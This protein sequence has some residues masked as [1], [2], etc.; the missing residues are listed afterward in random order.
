MLPTKIQ[1]NVLWVFFFCFLNLEKC[2]RGHVEKW[3]QWER[4]EKK[5]IIKLW[6]SMEIILYIYENAELKIYT[7]RH[8][9]HI[10]VGQTTDS[11][12]FS[13]LCIGVAAIQLKL[14]FIFWSWD[15]TFDEVYRNEIGFIYI[16]ISAVSNIWHIFV[17]NISTCS[18]CWAISSEICQAQFVFWFFFC[19]HN[20]FPTSAVIL[21]INFK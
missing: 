6:I 4:N 9:V 10:P 19:Q 18:L 11:S 1:P 13:V 3:S 5:I 2:F 17:E 8:I 14:I 7:T 20:I 16:V 15:D 12:V 21:K